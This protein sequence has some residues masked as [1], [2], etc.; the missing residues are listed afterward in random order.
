[1]LKKKQVSPNESEE[2]YDEINYAKNECEINRAA[3][4]LKLKRC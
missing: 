3:Y 4:W 2:D 1:M